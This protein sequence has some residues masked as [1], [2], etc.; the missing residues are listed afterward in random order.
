MTDDDEREGRRVVIL[1][2]ESRPVVPGKA[3]IGETLTM[4]GSPIPSLQLEKKKQNGSYGSGPD[5]TQLFVPYLPWPVIFRRLKGRGSPK[6]H[7][8]PGRRGRRSRAARKGD[9]SIYQILGREH[10]FGASDKD[11]LFTR[12]ARRLQVRE[13]FST[14]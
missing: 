10:H 13:R 8:Q 3:A 5:N 2:V 9:A 7:Q 11:A 4:D 6:I 1:G 14:S 12:Y